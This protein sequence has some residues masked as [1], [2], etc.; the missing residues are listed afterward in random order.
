MS[1]RDVVAVK[2]A[3]LALSC[4]Q[5]HDCVL[6]NH[7]SVKKVH[8]WLTPTRSCMFL[9]W[10]NTTAIVFRWRSF[11]CASQTLHQ[12]Y[13][14]LIRIRDS[15]CSRQYSIP[16]SSFHSSPVRNALGVSLLSKGTM[17]E[18]NRVSSLLF[19][20]LSLSP[21]FKKKNVNLGYPAVA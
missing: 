10:P 16:V 6:E 5:E 20:H 17:I 7:S 14:I 19:R 18:E 13:L 1:C 4:K 2:Q 21:L 3:E 12:L 11:V 9:P 8:V 15:R